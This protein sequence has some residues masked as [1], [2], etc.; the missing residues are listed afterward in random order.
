MKKLLLVV[1]T[2]P[3]LLAVTCG[4][5]ES[6]LCGEPTTRFRSNELAGVENPKEVYDLGDT[7]WFSVILN[8]VIDIDEGTNTLDISDYTNLKFHF[9][10]NRDSVFQ[11]QTWLCVNDE[12]L[13]IEQ[14]ELTFRCNEILFERQETQFV[15]RIGIKLLEVGAYNLAVKEISSFDED[16]ALSDITIATTFP[17]GTEEFEFM[18]Q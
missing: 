2:M 8:N 12:T 13:E 17:N 9:N 6:D 10:L 14:G 7:L 5:D 15:A 16:C 4:P 3:F 11:S 1:A 18:V